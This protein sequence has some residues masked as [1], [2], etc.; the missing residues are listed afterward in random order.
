MAMQIGFGNLGGIV[1]SN[2]Y[3]TTQAPR[4]KTGYGVS[5]ALLLMCGLMCTVFF[6]G[7]RAENKKRERGARDYRYTDERDELENMGDDHPEFRFTY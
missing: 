7:L 3:I 5:L 2:I 4:Y 6:F 1:A